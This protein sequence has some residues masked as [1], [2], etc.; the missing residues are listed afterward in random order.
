MA[1]VDRA[2]P[3]TVV[4]IGAVLAAERVMATGN[5]HCPRQRLQLGRQYEDFVAVDEIGSCVG[6]LV[7]QRQ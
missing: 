3:R 5:G 4:A 1:A 7:V 6:G 2:L